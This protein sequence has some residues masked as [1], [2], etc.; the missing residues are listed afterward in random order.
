MYKGASR[1]NPEKENISDGN[2]ADLGANIY[3]FKFYLA[4]VD[5][6][7]V[8]G[9]YNYSKPEMHSKYHYSSGLLGRVKGNKFICKLTYQFSS[10]PQS[11][12]T[13]CDPMDCST[14]GF[15]VHHQ[16]PEL[17]QTHVH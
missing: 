9:L 3:G 1:Q 7:H 15:P 10:V 6:C 14:P 5:V 8:D 17:A 4:F 12:P 13:F 2:T 11:C 16:F